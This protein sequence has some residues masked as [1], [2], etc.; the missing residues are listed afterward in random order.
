MPRNRVDPAPDGTWEP[1]A[2]ARAQHAP[3]LARKVRRFIPS[4]IHEMQAKLN[5]QAESTVRI[6]IQFWLS[7]Q[8]LIS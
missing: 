1:A 8:F 2:R 5:Q 7:A 6:K 4:I 3:E